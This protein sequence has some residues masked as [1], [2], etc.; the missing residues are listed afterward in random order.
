MLGARYKTAHDIVEDLVASKRFRE[1]AE[2]LAAALG[3]DAREVVAEARTALSE[4]A[5]V[6]NRFARDVWVQLARLLWARG[7]KLEV[8]VAGIERLRELGKRNP[9]VFLP[10]HKSNLDGFV[11]ASVMYDFGFPQNHVIGGKNMGFWPLGALGRRVGVVWI[12]RSFGDDPVY[13]FAL[14]RYL[15]HLASKRFNLEWYIEGGR[16]RSGKLLAPRMGLLN[17]LAQGVE[18]ADV[19]DVLLAPVSIVYDRLNEVLEMTAESR[20]AAKRPEGLRWLVRYARQQRGELGRVQVK[21]GEPVALR[22]A[23][24]TAPTGDSAARSIALSKAAF[25]VCTRINRNTPVTPISIA[26]LALLGMDGWAATLAQTQRAIEPLVRYVEQRALPGSES[27]A[28]LHTS[29]GLL[30]VLRTLTEHGVV[31]QFKGS[32][33]VYRISPER[34]LAAAF[35]RN[36]IVHWFVN[37]A[38]VEL[39]L[40]AAAEPGAGSDPIVASLAEAWRMRDLLKFEFFFAEKREF[41]AELR[42][43][44]G[45]IDPAW[46]Q[47]GGAELQTLGEMLAVSGG[48]MADRVL[49]SFLEAYYVVADRLAARGG[50]SVEE[51]DLVKDCLVVG[52]QYQLQRRT[53]SAEAVSSELYKTGLRLARNRELLTGD[54]KDLVQGRSAFVAELHDVLRRLEILTGWERRHRLRREGEIDHASP[55]LA[56]GAA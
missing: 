17:Y 30:Q 2:V 22:A 41:E 53:V 14:R 26:T 4:L 21:F 38:I 36:V 35:Y 56:G 34:E 29:E 54:A 47:K 39:A 18:E 20:G 46:R 51:P 27:L 25:E 24:A 23:L 49:R 12:R 19:P 45:L 11:M 16:S 40:V 43:E 5:S 55:R 10:S 28:P 6:Q 32:E 15:A 33:A 37:R 31:D 50:A 44:V 3:R 8:D 13:K 1:G 42:A 9:L 7:Y 48:L 52:R